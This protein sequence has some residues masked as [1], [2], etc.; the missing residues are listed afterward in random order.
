MQH[1]AKTQH[2]PAFIALAK[3]ENELHKAG[4]I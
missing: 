3:L 2:I 4:N 1:Q